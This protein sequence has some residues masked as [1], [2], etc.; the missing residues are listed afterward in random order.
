MLVGLVGK[1]NVGKSTFFNACT[2]AQ[3]AVGA[4]P[5]TTIDPNKGIAFAEAACPC[6]ELNVKCVPR[7][8]RCENGVR[9]IPINIVD[10]AGL[11]PDA[12]EGKGMGIQFLNDLSQA[13]A[14]LCIVDASGSTDDEGK[15]C[16]SGSHDPCRDVEILFTELDYWIAD[17]LKRNIAKAKGKT[18]SDLTQYLSGIRV[19]ES[20][21]KEA[22]EECE[23]REDFFKWSE[24]D[25]LSMATCFR[26]A[27][28]PTL[29]VANK[30]DLPKAEDCLN[31]LKQEFPSYI[32][33]PVSADSELALKRASE[34]GI[35]SYDG[36]KMSL[37]NEN[38]PP[39]LIEALNTIQHNVLDKYGSTGVQDV[40]NKAVFDLLKLI[41][42]YP[43]ED[44]KH[45]SDH[46]GNVL[47]DAIMLPQNSTPVALAERIHTDLAKGFLYAIDAR[48]N[49]RIAKDHFLKSGDITKIVSA[50]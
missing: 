19:S 30:I 4:Y 24:Q 37:L 11:V 16:P 29:I 45:F 33:V 17:I 1:T 12:H 40:I 38:L 3:A 41:V 48:K 18:L 34:K 35:I 27:T 44:E 28:K 42:V 6:K 46:F 2:H 25:L 26:K 50:R 7:N 47:P 5:F 43:V 8:S 20:V 22:M 15:A 13:D 14:L 36:K 39:K 23:L 32:I 10:V 9:K 49:M 21:L 31:R